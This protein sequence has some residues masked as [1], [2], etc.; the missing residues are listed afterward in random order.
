MKR[1]SVMKQFLSLLIISF[2]LIGTQLTAQIVETHEFGEINT[3]YFVYAQGT[4]WEFAAENNMTVE[5][6]E[7][8]SRLAAYNPGGTFHIEIRIEGN[9]VANW[10]QYVS[11]ETFMD[12]FNSKSVSVALHEGDLIE[13]RIWGGIANNAVGALTGISYVKLSSSGLAIEEHNDSYWISSTNYPNPFNHVTTIEFSLKQD[14]QT[15]ITVFDQCG[16]EIKKIIDD[17]IKSGEHKVQFDGSELAGG[18]Y[19]YTIS[20][21]KYRVTGKMLLIK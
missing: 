15:S 11:S 3:Q 13:Y 7:T 1:R 12:Y 17:H 9:L 6:I 5:N 21:G 20:S 8:K 18:L 10:D 4:S 14:A 19:F 16:M 2:L